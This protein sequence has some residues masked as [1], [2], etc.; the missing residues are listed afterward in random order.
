MSQRA[1]PAPMPGKLKFA[2]VAVWFQGLMNVLAA[3]LILSLVSDRVD[4]GQD[5]DAGVLRAMAYV[6]LLAAAALIAAAVLTLRR[7]DWVRV[8]VIVIEVILMAG[9]VFTLFSG[10]GPTVIVGL[11]LAVAVVTT[12]ASAES[13]AWF[14]R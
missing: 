8:A 13:K 3:V 2:L 10:G 11:L 7:L 4:H 5:E 6:S 12:F 14:A 1:V 9:A